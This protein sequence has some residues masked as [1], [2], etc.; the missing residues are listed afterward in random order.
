MTAHSASK[1]YYNSTF[2]ATESAILIENLRARFL[3]KQ[4]KKPTSFLSHLK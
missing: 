2:M 1:L 3:T 4:A